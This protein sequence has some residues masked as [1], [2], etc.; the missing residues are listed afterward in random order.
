MDRLSR[1][2][3]RLFQDFVNECLIGHRAARRAPADIG[4][5]A[6]RNAD[7]DELFCLARAGPA[8][9]AGSFEFSVRC[10]RDVGKIDSAIRHMLSALSGSPVTR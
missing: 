1:S 8:D 2:L 5:Q 3:G 6:R 4:E 9:A 7:G 10:L